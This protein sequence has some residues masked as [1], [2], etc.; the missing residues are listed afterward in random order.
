MLRN[1]SMS[2]SSGGLGGS[3]MQMQ[4]ASSVYGGA[5]GSGM[6]I[7]SA[8]RGFEA[9]GGSYGFG[10]GG[11]MDI[12]VGAN[13]KATMQNLNDR[14]ASYLEKVR[15][16]E[17]ANADLE[18]KIR[19]Y[20]EKKTGPTARDYS[21]YEA[22]IAELQGKI[23]EAIQKN[24]TVL[25]AQE[26]AKLAADDFKT[27]FENELAMRQSVE[28]D[29]GELRR[30]LDQLT[31]TRSDLEMQKES[32]QE[33]LVF[34][35]KNHQ[36]EMEAIR[37]QMSG[38]INV[39]VDAKPQQDLNKI[40]DE[41]REQYEAVAAKNQKELQAWFDAKSTALNKEVAVSSETLQTSKTEITD[42]RR[43]LQNLE[44]E[45]QS[46]LSMKSRLEENLAETQSRYAAKL[47]GFQMQVELLEEQLKQLHSDMKRQNQDYAMLL[48]IKTRLELEIAEYRRLLDGE[49]SAGSSGSSGSSTA[50]KVIVYTE[51]VK[52]RKVSSRT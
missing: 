10:S 1:S 15:K 49:A 9:A 20:L 16:L 43:T 38:Q 23:Q 26:N 17:Q 39:E 52:D 51:E 12:H 40:M 42:L 35:K 14:L 21:A 47:Q 46:Q 13:E 2:I 44:I 28:A 22:T 11:E 6:R 8:S 29:L 3:R 37:A 27:K 36:E 5:G 30:V 24:G 7:S 31:L 25:L 32:L 19:E 4:Y 48:D 34:L 41:I 50:K 33:E 45:L 18:L